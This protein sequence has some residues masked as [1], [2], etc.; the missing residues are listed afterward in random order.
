MQ[1]PALSP[2]EKAFLASARHEPSVLGYLAERVRCS[3]TASLG[4]PVRIAGASA[5]PGYRPHAGKA[6]EIVPSQEMVSAWVC[7]RFGGYP[8]VHGSP[9]S[10]SL[11]DS[12]ASTLKSA[13][14]ASVIN[15]G[16]TVVWPHEVR[17]ELTI[18]EL[19]G[20]VDY[21]C[22]PQYLMPWAKSEQERA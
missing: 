9:A 22:Q 21:F 19:N 10:G 2:E 8:H 14:A 20:V 16:D 6:P 4:V 1:L 13:L 3:M 18:Q 12:L 7:A 5:L 15:L 11:S 17:L